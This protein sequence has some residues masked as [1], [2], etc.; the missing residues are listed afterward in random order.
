[1][2]FSLPGLYQQNILHIQELGID[3]LRDMSKN[4]WRKTVEDYV[5]K[6][7]KTQVLEG[8]RDSKKLDFK[9]LSED[10]YERKSYLSE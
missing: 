6:I 10:I 5:S 8:I 4:Q 7:N 2:N 1:M 3:N 9:K